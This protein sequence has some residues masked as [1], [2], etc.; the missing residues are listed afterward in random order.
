MRVHP[1]T[2]LHAHPATV[3]CY[4]PVLPACY[5]RVLPASAHRHTVRAT[6]HLITAAI[7]PVTATIQD[8]PLVARAHI[9]RHMHAHVPVE[10]VAATVDEDNPAGHRH[11]SVTS[12]SS[13]YRRPFRPWAQVRPPQVP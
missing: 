4:R 5:R 3:L 1:A 13:S 7:E 8:N 6:R 11:D 9:N 10:P 12:T 2:R